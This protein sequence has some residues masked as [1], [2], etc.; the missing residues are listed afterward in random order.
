MRAIPETVVLAQRRGVFLSQERGAGWYRKLAPANWENVNFTGKLGSIEWLLLRVI[1]LFRKELESRAQASDASSASID[2]PPPGEA[3]SPGGAPQEP[4]DSSPPEHAG[5]RKPPRSKRGCK[6]LGCLFLIVVFA[7]FL[8]LYRMSRPLCDLRVRP[9]PTSLVIPYLW[10]LDE[11]TDVEVFK[12]LQL[13]MLAAADQEFVEAVRGLYFRV[14][15]VLK[16]LKQKHGN[17]YQLTVDGPEEFTEE[18]TNFGWKRCMSVMELYA[19][20]S[21]EQVSQIRVGDRVRGKVIIADIYRETPLPIIWRS[22][23]SDNLSRAIRSGNLRDILR[24]LPLWKRV[25]PHSIW[26]LDLDVKW[27]ERAGRFLPPPRW[28]IVFR[29]GS[30]CQ[31][32]A[33]EGIP[34]IGPA[35]SPWSCD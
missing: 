24:C 14:T 20:L 34:L 28:I 6:V 25:L 33:V 21:E 19:V 3:A 10:R 5:P 13:Q 32:G 15:G 12:D 11:I 30:I 8:L 9:F 17:L 31:V 1:S 23:D 27:E 4:K 26:K 22:E 35:D 2:S 16:E 7:I 18:L 29:A